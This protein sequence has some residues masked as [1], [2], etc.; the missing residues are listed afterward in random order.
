MNHKAH[1][2]AGVCAG[3]ITATLLYQ[4]DLESGNVLIALAPMVAGGY[5][6]GLLPDI[7]HPGSKLGRALYPIAW[8]IN[9]IFGHRGATH[10]L[11]AF[12]LTSVLFLIPSFVMGGVVGFLYTQFAIGISVGFLSHLLL[13]MSTK[14]GVPLLYP[15]TRKSFRISKLTTGKHDWVVSTIAIL[16]TATTIYLS[17]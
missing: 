4:N 3:T 8:V 10:S 1:K 6:G 9:K 11:L 2:I 14:S 17:F 16:L 7:D 13:D 15:F 5:L 12:F